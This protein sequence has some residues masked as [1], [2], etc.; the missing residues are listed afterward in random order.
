MLCL[1]GCGR[2]TSICGCTNKRYGMKKGSPNKYIK[3]HN[4]PLLGKKRKP[5]SEEYRKKQ[6]ESHLG[7]K[8]NMSKEGSL[9]LSMK[10]SKPKTVES[11]MKM[12][13]SL[14]GRKLSSEHIK[15]TMRRRPITSLEAKFIEIIKDNNLPFKFVGNGDFI[16]DGLNPD[17]I[18]TGGEKIAIEVYSKFYKEIKGRSVEEYKTKRIE[19]LSKHG[20]KVLFF[21]ETQVNNDYVKNALLVGW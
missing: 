10:A 17:F 2:E 15:N 14:T 13:A 7:R 11:I 8:Y 21:D 6:R 9:V 3:G 16:I 19:R 20:W 1:C 18:N 5:Y 4:R 12:K